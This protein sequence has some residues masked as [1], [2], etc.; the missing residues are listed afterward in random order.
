MDLKKSNST[1]SS[2]AS[3]KLTD[4][5][6]KNRKV[7]GY[8]IVVSIILIIAGALFFFTFS[9]A[10]DQSSWVTPLIVFSLYIIVFFILAL[11]AGKKK[12]AL[13][14]TIISLTTSAFFAP[15][16]LH[17]ATILVA[18]LLV[19][20]S[21]V[22]IRNGLFSTLKVEAGRALHAGVIPFV[23]GLSIVISSQYYFI[24]NQYDKATLMQRAIGSNTSA[25]IDITSKILTFFQTDKEK[26][27]TT[28]D[29]YLQD[30][31]FTTKSEESTTPSLFDSFTQSTGLD[32][33]VIRE[34]AEI[35]PELQDQLQVSL[36]EETRQQISQNIGIDLTGSERITDVL[37]DVA[38]MKAQKLVEE[39]AAIAGAVPIILT[40]FLF[41]TLV[42]IGSLLRFFWIMFAQ[43]VF[44]ILKFYDI[45]ETIYVKKDVEVIKF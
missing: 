44:W 16:A 39:N 23:I 7:R 13:I 17:I 28:I 26:E 40:I 8:D 37:A 30:T 29:K 38:K 11:T 24:V 45:I 20:R 5:R 6:K 35:L 3:T 12:F 10:V 33:S 4:M 41:I 42:S 21:I 1:I 32:P 36:L 43:I 2:E 14:A 22:L 18:T 9:K 19:W 34:Q 15:K 27:S 25:T 31:F